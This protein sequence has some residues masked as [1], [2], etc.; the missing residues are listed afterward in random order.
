MTDFQRKA[1]RDALEQYGMR[2][3]ARSDTNRAWR[4]AVER[5]L[6]YYDVKDAARAQMLRLRYIEKRREDDVIAM[7]HMG[8]TT[9]KNALTDLL[10][11]VAVFAA[12]EG[13]FPD[14]SLADLAL[15]GHKR[16]KKTRT[17]CPGRAAS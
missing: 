16:D 10:S 14:T 5:T 8:R 4:R 2:R 6:A 13:A 3:W 9:Y 12:Q 15:A 11:T 1:A 17:K 7:L